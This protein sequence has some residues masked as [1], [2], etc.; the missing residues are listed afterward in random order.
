MI[1]N[2]YLRYC[3]CFCNYIFVCMLKQERHAFILDQIHAS[4]KVMTI[5][6]SLELKV[7]EDTIRRDLKELADSGKL[8][9][10]HGGAISHSL[11]PFHY[12]DREVYALEEKIFIAEKAKNLIKDHQVIFIDG[13]TTNLELAR[14][15]PQDLKA[16]IFTNSL[17]IAVLLADHPNINLFVTGGKLLK[18][19]QV[20]VGPEVLQMLAGLRVDVCIL[21]TRSIHHQIGISEIDW[22]ET[23]VKRAAIKASSEVICLVIPEKIGT[24][25]PYI[26]SE[27]QQVTTL[28]SLLD[29]NDKRLRP[30]YEFGIEIL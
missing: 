14:R 9:K 3:A 5:D 12:K 27:I 28:V 20:T 22:D 10:V 1:L 7:S 11:N 25:N 23:Q 29:K 18:D 15:L 8:K 21:G 24:T 4:G 16:T 26:I 19:A 6:L 17:P 30:Y 13:G 2:N